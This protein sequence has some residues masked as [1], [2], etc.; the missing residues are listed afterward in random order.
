MIDE[1]TS[2]ATSAI[3]E[4]LL[5]G[6]WNSFWNRIEPCAVLDIFSNDSYIQ[7]QEN[8]PSSLYYSRL[9]CNFS[10]S[11]FHQCRLS[12]H[13]S[14]SRYHHS[15]FPKISLNMIIMT[16]VITMMISQIPLNTAIL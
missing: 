4:F 1:T 12:S 7:D 2:R 9:G 3:L 14:S 8:E 6:P 16:F 5:P 13:T 15:S 10:G 11:L